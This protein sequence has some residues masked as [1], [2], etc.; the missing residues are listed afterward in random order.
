[1]T[2][3]VEATSPPV[4][5]RVDES[6]LERVGRR[7]SLGDYVTRL[8]RL[9]HYVRYDAVAAVQAQNRRHRLGNVWLLLNPI[10]NGATYFLVFGV[11]LRTSLG[12]EN[13][14]GY[15]TVG[16]F[17]FTF[18][19]R[20]VTALSRSLTARN[21]VAD[22]FQLPRAVLPL[23]ALAR[24]VLAYGFTLAAMLLAV[25]I[26]PP[27]AQVTWWW[28]LFPV[29][30]A[31]QLMLVAG[32]GLLLAR[33]VS[34]VRDLSQIV[35]FGIRLWMYGSAVFY[36]FDRFV[37][38]PN[39]LAVLQLNPMYQVLDISR[40][41]LLYGRSPSP[42]AWGILAAWSVGLLVV[43]VVVFW[44]GEERYAKDLNR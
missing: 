41:L 28:L 22:A 3:R 44:L 19:T 21:N 30:V 5:L 17:M 16:V 4:E 33:A 31:L 38:Q 26:L 27:H 32:V 14:I 8:W 11:L 9:R 43:G 35:G 24:E 13:F 36:S 2:D 7:P 15:L 6:R 39:V 42:V 29:V 23:T 10:L 40:D 20:A 37:S 25:L 1:M 18:T 34:R 12:V